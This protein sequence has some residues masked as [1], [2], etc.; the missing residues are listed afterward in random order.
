MNYE[1]KGEPMPVVICHLDAGESMVTEKGS[2]V[3]M[4]HN[5]EMQTSSGGVGKALGRMLSRESMFQNVYT[6]KREPG[7]IAFASSVPG[8]IRTVELGAGKTI[9]AQKSA[10]LASEPGVELSVFFQK[11]LGAGFFGGEGFIMQKLS[12]Q[13][14]VFLEIDGSAVEYDLA[15]GQQMIVDTGN[16]AMMDETCSIDIQS[17]KG[18]KNALFGGEGIIEVKYSVYP[19]TFNESGAAHLSYKYPDHNEKIRVV[20][21]EAIAVRSY[22]NKFFDPNLRIDAAEDL[23]TLQAAERQHRTAS[24]VVAVVVVVLTA[25]IAAAYAAPG[26][27]QRIVK[28]GVEVRTAYLSQY[29]DTITVEDAFDNFFDNGKWST[30]KDKDY[31]Y[32]AFTG[33][34]EYLGER[35]DV[36]VT[37]KIT[38]ERFSVDSLDINGQE[39][40]NLILYALLSKVYED[41]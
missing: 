38:G 39:Q 4:S 35:A 24:L 21:L 26:T 31:S 40:N 23:K 7:L 34:C 22:I 19:V 5:M 25:V 12:G 36:K 37:F 14:T 9:V 33:A 30:Y 29:S 1:I 11:K 20:M 8:V 32:V 6:A 27:L 13:G 17:V 28:P 16:L 2:M 10:F 41:Y 18:V 15:P 3:W